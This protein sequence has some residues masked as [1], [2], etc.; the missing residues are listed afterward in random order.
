MILPGITIVA[1]C[2]LVSS[3]IAALRIGGKY[4][5]S[6]FA[7]HELRSVPVGVAQGGN[8]AHEMNDDLKDLKEQLDDI[9]DGIEH[10]SEQLARVRD[11]LEAVQH[12][13]ALVR[14]G[15][16]AERG[17]QQELFKK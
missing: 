1:R 13:C 10:V 5:R 6:D 2:S 4:A 9:T 15:Q 16:L 3:K 7:R 14:A 11:M 12:V 17:L 8:M